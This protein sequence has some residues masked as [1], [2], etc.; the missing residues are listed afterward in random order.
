MSHITIN[1]HRLNPKGVLEV[2]AKIPRGGGGPGGGQGFQE[3]MP[4]RFPLL[5]VLLHFNQKNFKNLP[6]GRWGVV[7]FHLPPPPTPCASMHLAGY[8]IQ[9][10]FQIKLHQKGLI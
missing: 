1:A 2:F 10:K 9:I 4:V 6:G 5:Q 8:A 7:L 3:K